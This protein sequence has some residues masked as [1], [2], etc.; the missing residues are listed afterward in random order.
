MLHFDFIYHAATQVPCKGT[1]QR[2]QLQSSVTGTHAVESCLD[3]GSTKKSPALR[4][5]PWLKS[6]MLPCMRATL[7]V[8][9]PFQASPPHHIGRS[10]DQE[11]YLTFSSTCSKHLQDRPR[12]RE[13]HT[14][15]IQN[16]QHMLHCR[17]ASL[18]SIYTTKIL[19]SVH[20]SQ[21]VQVIDTTACL[22]PTT[23]SYT[24]LTL[25]TILLV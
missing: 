18:K 16:I 23:V 22:T 21:H 13:N 24:H 4:L 3:S 8:C 20:A 6:T 5:N 10:M 1:T 15:A 2:F 19:L 7:H 12:A 17:T 11:P 14:K 25:P 9:S